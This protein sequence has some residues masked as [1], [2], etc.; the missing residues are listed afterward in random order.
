MARTMTMDEQLCF[1]IEK[2]RERCD[3]QYADALLKEIG[4]GETVVGLE[5]LYENLLDDEVTIDPELLDAI[6]R[7]G[8]LWGLRP[9]K[10]ERLRARQAHRS[11]LRK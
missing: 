5:N 6:E 3:P 10:W 2:L 1:F 11:T 7:L 8:R 4:Y 9:A